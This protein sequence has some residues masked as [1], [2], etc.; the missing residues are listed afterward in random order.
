MN[1]D[2]E[3]YEDDYEEDYDDEY[4]DGDESCDE[5]DEESVVVMTSEI[6]YDTIRAVAL[7]N[8]SESHSCTECCN[9]GQRR[10]SGHILC[11]DCMSVWEEMYRIDLDVREK[12]YSQ[13]CRWIQ[14][15][16]NYSYELFCEKFAN[17]IE[18]FVPE[19][20]ISKRAEI[21]GKLIACLK[22]MERIKLLELDT[23]YID[24]LINSV[25]QRW[26]LVEGI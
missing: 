12:L 19:I 20:A 25:S 17:E 14:R 15:G 23:K 11:L 10:A 5:R 24:D 13:I 22:E 7:H 1:E 9:C 6:I 16:E 4:Y 3:E 2:Y 8:Y 21:V 18:C 26:N